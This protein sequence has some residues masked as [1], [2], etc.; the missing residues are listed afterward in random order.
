MDFHCAR[1]DDLPLWG[2]SFILGS[3][4]FHLVEDMLVTFLYSSSNNKTLM[5]SPHIK[6][7]QVA[8]RS[9]RA[10]RPLHF[11]SYYKKFELLKYQNVMG[12]D[13]AAG[14]CFGSHGCSAQILFKTWVHLG[15]YFQSA[16]A[17]PTSFYHVFEFCCVVILIIFHVCGRPQ[18]GLSEALCSE[19]GVSSAWP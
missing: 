6:K 3:C 2:C 10:S 18:P 13:L 9:Q 16:S 19:S 11:L 17:D 7:V 1:L 15:G 12:F 14:C 4:C 8:W 5:L